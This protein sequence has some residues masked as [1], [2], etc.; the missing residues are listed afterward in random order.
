MASEFTMETAFELE[1][2]LRSI[3]RELDRQRTELR[4]ELTAAFRRLNGEAL[5]NASERAYPFTTAEK[6]AVRR[7]TVGP[8]KLLPE[9]EERYRDLR[10]DQQTARQRLGEFHRD[11]FAALAEDEPYTVTVSEP[12]TNLTQPYLEVRARHEDRRVVLSVDN[13]VTRG[14]AYCESPAYTDRDVENALG[15]CADIEDVDIDRLGLRTYNTDLVD[16]TQIRNESDDPEQLRRQVQVEILETLEDLE[17]ESV[18][19]EQSPL[20]TFVETV[21]AAEFTQE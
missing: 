15:L 18:D 14:Y 9:W 5:H 12:R 1:A 10:D 11:A 16:F 13:P 2:E 6:R 17:F 7:E 21:D 3:E 4:E 8:V 20:L 19:T